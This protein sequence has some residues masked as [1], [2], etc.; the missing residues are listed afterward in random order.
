MQITKSKVIFETLDDYSGCH[1]KNISGS[2]CHKALTKWV[3][4]HPSD[5]FKAAKLTRLHMN[6]WLAV[7][8]FEKSVGQPDFNCKDSDL[9]LAVVGGLNL[10]KTGNEKVIESSEKI[11]FEK[12]SKEMKKSVTEA[13]VLDS[14][15]FVNVCH[16]LEL[17]GI[18]KSRCEN[19]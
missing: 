19:L 11:A 6:H 17:T 13:A 14:N 3:K 15:L 2:L 1:E 16:K 18:K 7:P 5:A 10:P 8:F 4:A 12:C 9:K